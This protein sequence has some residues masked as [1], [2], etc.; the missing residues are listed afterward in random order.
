MIWSGPEIVADADPHAAHVSL[1]DVM[2]TL[3]EAVGI[4]LPAG[5]QGRSLW[6][7]LTG[8][9]YPEAEFESVYAEQG[10]GGLHYEA[11]DTNRGPGGRR[12]EPRGLV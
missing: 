6:P 3:C 2:P 5:V 8:G 9:A 7:M 4:E 10:F 11:R 1:V 12:A